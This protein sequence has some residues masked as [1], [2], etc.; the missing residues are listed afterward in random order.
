[1]SDLVA[2]NII[3]EPESELERAQRKEELK[4]ILVRKVCPCV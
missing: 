4:A 1:V 2:Q 3:R